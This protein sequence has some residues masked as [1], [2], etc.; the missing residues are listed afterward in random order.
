MEQL[1]DIQGGRRPLQPAIPEVH[2][3][4]DFTILIRLK[5]IYNF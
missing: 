4:D 5:R 3:L 1:P 2:R